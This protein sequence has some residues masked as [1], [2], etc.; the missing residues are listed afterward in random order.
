MFNFNISIDY[1]D[2]FVT[3]IITTTTTFRNMIL[4]HTGGYLAC[5][6]LVAVYTR[7]GIIEWLKVPDFIPELYFI[8][9]KCTKQF[10]A[11]YDYLECKETWL[12]S[13]LILWCKYNKPGL[14]PK[15]RYFHISTPNI[16]NLK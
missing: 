5:H 14:H 4:I 12:M 15:Q 8:S 13:I 10:D 11:L 16:L 2:Q 6:C 1:F 3:I 7:T 9:L